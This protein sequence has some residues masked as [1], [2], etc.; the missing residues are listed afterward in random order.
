MMEAYFHGAREQSRFH[1]LYWTH[2][3]SQDTHIPIMQDLS[4]LL[5]SNGA[6]FQQIN[7]FVVDRRYT[8]TTWIVLPLC[9]FRIRGGGKHQAFP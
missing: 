2:I 9:L 6:T 3:G 8:T 1:R 4:I 5:R 7:S